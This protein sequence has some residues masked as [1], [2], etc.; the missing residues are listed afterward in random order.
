MT[1][2]K[3]RRKI[4][5]LLK[6]N[7]SSNYYY[8]S[9]TAVFNENKD[10]GVSKYKIDRWDFKRKFENDKCVLIKSFIKTSTDTNSKNKIKKITT[11][12]KTHGN[13]NS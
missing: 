6:K 8:G 4:F 9:L 2:I 13:S 3:K 7:S 12:T 10:L 11:K 1:V 5:H